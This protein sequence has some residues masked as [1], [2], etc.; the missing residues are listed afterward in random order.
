MFEDC[1]ALTSLTIPR[2]LAATSEGTFNRAAGLKEL[3]FP[4]GFQQVG[5]TTFTN[6][7]NLKKVVFPASLTSIYGSYYGTKPFNGTTDLT[8]V[9]LGKTGEQISAMPNFS[10]WGGTRLVV[11]GWIPASQEWVESQIP[12][13]TSQL[14]NDSG[15]VDQS[16]LENYYTRSETSSAAEISEALG[17]INTI[18]EALN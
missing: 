18:L 2:G 14:N 15:F 5:P 11:S 3:Q 7:I 4:D 9:F 16:A 13:S 17:D 6:C 1:S 8:A 10:Q 12:T